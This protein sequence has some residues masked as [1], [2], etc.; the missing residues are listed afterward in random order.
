MDYKEIYN[1]WL[2]SPVVDNDTKEELRAIAND[3]NEIKERVYKNLEFGTGFVR[4][5]K[6]A[7]RKLW[8]QVLL[9][10]TTPVTNQQYLLWKVLKSLRQTVAKHMC[11]TNF[12]PHPNFLLP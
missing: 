1:S 10:P 11:S 9:L 2:A 8:R 12:V 5:S 4:I 3:E 7:A 6:I